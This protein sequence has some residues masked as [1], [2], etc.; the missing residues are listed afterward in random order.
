LQA[1]VTQLSKDGYD[2]HLIWGD[3]TNAA[4]VRQVMVLGPF[5][6]ILIDGGHTLPFVRSD[7]MNYGPMGKIVAFHD[8]AWKRDP[9]WDGYQIDVPLFWENIKD[10]YNHQEIRLDPTGR[11]NGI[12]ILWVRP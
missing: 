12:G 8:I 10:T 11:D 7:W 6:L 9:G 1:C 2:A 4:V 5:D 3:S